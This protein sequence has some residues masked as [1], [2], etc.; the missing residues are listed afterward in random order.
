MYQSSFVEE[1]RQPLGRQ[2]LRGEPAGGVLEREVQDRLHP[3]VGRV[4]RG[5]ALGG[6]VAAV[7]RHLA[8]HEE[9]GLPVP[10]RVVEDP[11]TELLPELVVDVL[12]R[13]D[14]VAVDAELADPGPVDLGHALDHLRLL[15]EEVVEPEEVAVLAVLAGEGRVSAVVVAP[16]VVEPG[17]DLEVLLGRVQHRLVRERRRGIQRGEARRAGVVAVVERLA[18]RGAVGRHVL[19][20]VPRPCALLVADHVGGVVG[21]DVE[22][23]LHPL[24]VRGL[25]QCGEVGVGAEVGVDLGEVGDP[26]A[27]VAGGRPVLELDR[28][29]LEDRGQPDRVGPQALDVV[30]LRAEAREVTPVV[31]ALGGAGRTR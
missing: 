15:G 29:V 7:E 5:E 2:P 19:R 12:H 3:V 24:L 13:V 31:E 25:D 30:E 27:V 26:V 14:A 8:E 20:D 28:L 18:A 1:R 4:V 11:G 17:R 9:V 22:E 10:V 21:D 6:R 16:R 23:D